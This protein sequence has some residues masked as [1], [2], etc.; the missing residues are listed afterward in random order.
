MQKLPA[1]VRSRFRWLLMQKLSATARF[2]FRWLLYAEAIRY[3]AVLVSVAS[4]QKLSATV[5]FWFRWLLNCRSCPLH[6]AKDKGGDSRLYRGTTRGP[7]NRR[8]E[9]LQRDCSRQQDEREYAR[10]QD[11]GVYA[12][13]QDERDYAVGQDETTLVNKTRLGS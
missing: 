12:R 4:M 5:R 9:G 13:E 1:T 6:A 7:P 2:W 3:I 10:E 8:L 11:E